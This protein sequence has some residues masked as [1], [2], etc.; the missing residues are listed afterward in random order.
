[1]YVPPAFREDRPE[2]LRDAIRR[3][4]LAILVSV[5][6]DGIIA[7]HVPMLLDA[8]VGSNGMLLGH[9]ARANPQWRTKTPEVEGL[10]IFTGP[11]AYISPNWY[12]TK[13]ETG[14]VV[15]TWNYIAVH[16]YGRLI[17]FDDRE[18]L[19]ALVTRLTERHEGALPKPWAVSDAPADFVNAQ[20]KGIVGFRM[21]IT[22]L[23][24]KW[25]MSQN[26]PA[27]DR[28]GVVEGLRQQGG[29]VQ[30]AVADEVADAMRSGKPEA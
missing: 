29:A 8:A 22:R 16:V 12:A 20:L 19:R 7:S 11:E 3:T 17:F 24:G 27:V 18:P 1:M 26:R 15:P 9:I 5:G 23:E 2:V 14:K 30:A 10:A 13:R 21:E 28:L 4:D 25:K 6:P